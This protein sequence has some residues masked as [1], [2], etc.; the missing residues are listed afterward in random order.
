METNSQ[1]VRALRRIQRTP[2][3]ILEEYVTTMPEQIAAAMSAEAQLGRPDRSVRVGSTQLI[4]IRGVITHH[5]SLWELFGFESSTERIGQQ[6]QE[7]ADDD[8]IK[9]VVLDFN[10]PGGTTTGVE[11][12]AAQVR[13]VRKSKPVVAI[14][15]SL[16][17]S[18]A[19]HIASGASE[20]VALPSGDVGSIGVFIAHL[21]LS[22][23]EE[24]LGVKTTLVTAG[25][26]KAEF[27]F[28]KPLSDEARERLQSIADQVYSIFLRDVAKGR[29]VSVP[30][31]RN[32][33]GQGRLL[34]AREALSAGLVDRLG[35]LEETLL[36]VSGPGRGRIGKNRSELS[37]REFEDGI[38]AQFGFTR[39]Q[40]KAVALKG[41]KAAGE[42]EPREEAGAGDSEPRE[43]AEEQ[44][45][46][47]VLNNF[48]ASIST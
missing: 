23:F 46:A 8:D 16:M 24:K 11:E 20:I 19:Y 25:K 27:D 33:F 39:E 35:T 21:D 34:L 2:W 45:I 42:L 22:G 44:Q 13:E 47:A 10:S 30:T 17:A 6:L 18:A 3:A 43:E 14:A 7:A 26:F 4:P 40:A 29:G 48:A 12:L 9:A 5:S 28:S 36:R 38:H 37:I 1:L 41:F 32:D 15:N 31:V